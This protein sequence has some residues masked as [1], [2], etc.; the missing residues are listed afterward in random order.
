MSTDLGNLP[1]SLPKTPIPPDTN[2][3][4]VAISFETQLKNLSVEDF[5]EDALWRDTFALTG[6]IRTFYSA[7][8]TFI[9]WRRTCETLQVTSFAVDAESSRI[10][11]IGDESAWV[12]VPFTFKTSAPPA[13]LCSGSVSLVPDSNG[14]WKI[15]VLR[16]ILEQLKGQENADVL[17]VRSKTTQSSANG[18]VESKHFECAVVGG[19]P[20]GLSMSGRLQALGISYI[21]L[22]KNKEV[23]DCWKGRYSSAKCSLN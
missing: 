5:F 8:T 2:P 6:T 14:K 19:G 3:A 20:S 18:S 1:C 10:T 13:T 16:T 17:E 11:R 9:S 22:D 15:W 23:G 4:K 7:S 12:D 21:M